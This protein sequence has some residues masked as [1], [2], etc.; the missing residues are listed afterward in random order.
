MGRGRRQLRRHHRSQ[1]GDR[2]H[3]LHRHGARACRAAPI[4]RPTA[5]RSSRSPTISPIATCTP[6]DI[7][8]DPPQDAS[9][10]IADLFERAFETASLFNLDAMR[11]RAITRTSYSSLARTIKS[12]RRW[13]DRSMTAK[14]RGLK[15]DELERKSRLTPTRLRICFPIR[16]AKSGP[17]PAAL[18]RGRTVRARQ[19]VRRR[20]ADRFPQRQRGPGEEAGAAAVWPVSGACAKSPRTNPT[21][22]FRDPRVDRDTYHDMRMPPYMRDSDQ[23]P[24]SI[25]HRQYDELMQ[26]IECL[27]SPAGRETRRR[28]AGAR[29]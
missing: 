3:P 13:T 1:R 12:C 16:R 9:H 6:I 20:D 8:D 17:V 22:S 28:R 11:T 10:E 2:Q 5:G 27:K 18:F 23:N 24:L 25:T 21:A 26:L 14:D 7:D 29:S 19:A 4:L 15:P